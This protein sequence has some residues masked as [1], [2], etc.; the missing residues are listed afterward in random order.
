MTAFN[1]GALDWDEVD[2]KS[3]LETGDMPPVWNGTKYPRWI[4]GVLVTI[5]EI[6]NGGLI[7]GGGGGSDGILSSRIGLIGGGRGWRLSLSSFS[8]HVWVWKSELFEKLS[9]WWVEE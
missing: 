8:E 3:A 1:V 4:S 7:G 5:L 9:L 6:D 2:W